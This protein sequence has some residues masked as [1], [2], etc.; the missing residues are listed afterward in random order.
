MAEP[1]Q[2]ASHTN[3]ERCP[4]SLQARDLELKVEI[5][6]ALL[7]LVEDFSASKLLHPRPSQIPPVGARRNKCSVHATSPNEEGGD[8]FS[9]SHNPADSELSEGVIIGRGAE[10][11][12]YKARGK[13]GGYVAVKRLYTQS[14]LRASSSAAAVQALHHVHVVRHIA[15]GSG[16]QVMEFCDGGSLADVLSRSGPLGE[17]RVARAVVHVL[18][19]LAFLHSQ[20]VIHRD[21]KPGNI[22][23]DTFQDTFKL[24]DW[25]VGEA[26]TGSNTR[27]SGLIGT[28]AFLAPEVVRTGQHVEASDTWAV[29]CT[30]VNALSGKLPWQDEDN[31]FAAMFKAAHGQAPPFDIANVSEPFKQLLA[32]C[33]E[34]D[35]SLRPAPSTLLAHPSS[36]EHP[37]AT[38]CRDERR[39]WGL[40]GFVHVEPRS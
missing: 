9:P 20:G 30:V 18:R 23:V 19:G 36:A 6:S 11:H 10:S 28:P 13:E 17:E 8:A 37:W 7:Q 34:P 39:D 5:G 14:G 33:F 4:S 3:V 35:S 15:S 1:L 12:V 27:S 40:S 29:G 24:C 22:L 16:W 25:I 38:S 2:A 26:T 31:K 32:A 21:V